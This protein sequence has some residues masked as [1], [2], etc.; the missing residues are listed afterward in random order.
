MDQ[1]TPLSPTVFCTPLQQH[2][3]PTIQYR[4]SSVL[5][6]Y[7]GLSVVITNKIILLDLISFLEIEPHTCNSRLATWVWSTLNE[8]SFSVICKLEYQLIWHKKVRCVNFSKRIKGATSKGAASSKNVFEKMM[9]Y[10]TKHYDLCFDIN[11]VLL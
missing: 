9:Q 7:L 8:F 2:D 1:L 10:C 3:P 5:V 11:C 6:W 4:I